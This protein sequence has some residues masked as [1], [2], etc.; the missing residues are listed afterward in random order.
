MLKQSDSDGK[1]RRQNA[2]FRNSISKDPNADFPAEKDRYVL[3]MNYGCPWL[4]Q[5]NATSSVCAE[6]LLR[7]AHRTNIVRSLKGLE[8]VVQMVRPSC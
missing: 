5:S 6:L 4:V 2:Q 8:D 1:F 3:Y 7:R